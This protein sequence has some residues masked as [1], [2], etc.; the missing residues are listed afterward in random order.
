MPPSFSRPFFSVFL[1][2]FSPPTQLTHS[3]LVSQCSGGSIVTSATTGTAAPTPC[4]SGS[5]LGN[6]TLTLAPGT[7]FNDAVPA[8]ARPIAQ[9]VVRNESWVYGQT[10]LLPNTAV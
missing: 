1:S 9:C 2:V 5:C 8:T 7:F 10:T 3:S 6:G 4:T